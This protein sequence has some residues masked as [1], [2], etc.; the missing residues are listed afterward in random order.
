MLFSVRNGLSAVSVALQ[1]EGLDGS[2]RNLLW[3][4]LYS[5]PIADGGHLGFEEFGRPSTASQR[6]IVGEVLKL[7]VSDHLFSKGARAEIEDTFDKG[8]YSKVFDIIELVLRE[9]YTTQQAGLRDRINL[10]FEAQNVGYRVIGTDISLVTDATSTAAIETALESKTIPEHVKEHLQKA[11]RALGRAEESNPVESLNE[12]IKAVEAAAKI[13]AQNE[14]ATLGEALKAI[15]DRFG[16]HVLWLTA[17]E[18]LYAFA[19]DE[20]GVRHGSKGESPDVSVEDARL[21]L[22]VSSAMCE[23]LLVKSSRM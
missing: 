12:S 7:K 5:V 22:V 3:N 16:T 15:K 11:I 10:L 18:K 23:W 6:M 1:T 20:G 2:T 14:K 13:V 21:S 8:E 4:A 17:I 9:C 19:S